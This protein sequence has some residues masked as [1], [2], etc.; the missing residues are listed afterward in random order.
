[1]SKTQAYLENSQD[2]WRLSKIHFLNRKIKVNFC[3]ILQAIIM[4]RS[5]PIMEILF[6]HNKLFRT[7]AADNHMNM[8]IKEIMKIF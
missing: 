5:Q 7:N 2:S 1:M 3:F 4:E 8:N 6:K